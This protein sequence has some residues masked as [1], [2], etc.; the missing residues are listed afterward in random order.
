MKRSFVL[1][2]VP[3][4]QCVKLFS[5][6][7]IQFLRPQF[8]V[9]QGIVK[10]R[11]PLLPRLH[12]MSNSATADSDANNRGSAHKTSNLPP[13]EKSYE[14][15]ESSDSFQSIYGGATQSSAHEGYNNGGFR[16]RRD[17][18]A[19]SSSGTSSFLRGLN[20]PGPA[21]RVLLPPQGNRSTTS[22]A[23]SF[24]PYQPGPHYTNVIHQTVPSHYPSPY[25]PPIPPSDQTHRSSSSSGGGS[26][27]QA[28]SSPT[29][30]HPDLTV[31]NQFYKCAGCTRV[32]NRSDW[33]SHQ[34]STYNPYSGRVG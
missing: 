13:T 17:E 22:V 33:Y 9:F 3:C 30:P 32:V 23:S 16:P 27:F 24:D 19:N 12:M 21:N 34:C 15:S 5:I 8:H 4:T 1:F 26:H 2:Q 14:S 28:P 18:T 11:Q 25:A 20:T 31:N 10:Q 7:S 29:A 6:I